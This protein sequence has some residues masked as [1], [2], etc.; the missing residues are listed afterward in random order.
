M[1]DSGWVGAA[2][3]RQGTCSGQMGQEC[4]KSVDN[5]LKVLQSITYSC[6]GFCSEALAAV[7]AEEAYRVLT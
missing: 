7:A 4:P 3:A 2:C 1:R 6:H 5:L